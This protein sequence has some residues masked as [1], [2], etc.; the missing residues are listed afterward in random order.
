MENLVSPELVV[1]VVSG[2]II[3][4]LVGVLKG[5]LKKYSPRLVVAIISMLAGS[6]YYG[7]YAYVPE[8]LQLEIV[9]FVYGTLSSAVFLYAFI[10]KGLKKET[11]KTVTKTNKKLTK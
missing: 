4:I 11:P 10:W 8:V 5:P 7:F 9:N 1:S 6:L 2:G 3:S